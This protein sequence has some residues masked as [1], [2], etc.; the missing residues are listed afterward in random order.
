MRPVHLSIAGLVMAVAALSGCPTQP[1]ETDAGAVV[2]L[3]L[4]TAGGPVEVFKGIP[5]AAPPVGEMRWQPPGPA[6]SWEGIRPGFFATPPCMQGSGLLAASSIVPPSPDPCEDCLY[7][8]V[9]RP[10]NASEEPLPVMVWYHGGSFQSGT[11]DFPAY[12]GSALANQ[13]VIVVT[14][15]SRLGAFGYMAHP[16]F[17]AESPDGISGNYGVL[18]KIAALEWV[19]R[20]AAAFGGDPGN[21]TVF[22]ISSGA[23]GVGCLLVSP[24]AEGLF[25]RAI[26]QGGSTWPL[27]P[28]R[29]DVPGEDVPGE[30]FP[31]EL[32]SAEEIGLVTAESL[33]ISGTGPAAAAALRALPPADILEAENGSD[34]FAFRLGDNPT[35]DG[36]VIPEQPILMLQAGDFNR[37]PLLIGSNRDEASGYLVIYDEFLRWRAPQYTAFIHEFFGQDAE[38]ILALYPPRGQFFVWAELNRLVTDIAF[39]APARMFAHATAEAG[40]PAYRYYFTQRPGNI[41]GDVFGAHHAAEVPFVFNTLIARSHFTPED[42]ALARTMQ[43]YWTRFAATGDPNGPGDPEWPLDSPDADTLLELGPQIGAR[44]H[45][46]QEEADI[47]AQFLQGLYEAA[48]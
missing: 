33:A 1:V 37:I 18:D 17:S 40:L 26:M 3:R 7:L 45:Y 15:N 34:I 32:P 19:Q 46:R 29:A 27:P 43:R 22:G 21:V 12:D 42:R 39:F 14:V 35:V 30:V 44:S 11:G 13:G 23:M 36:V 2:G 25:H 9:W 20:N 41:A 28:L 10:A 4:Q 8:T 24:L 38:A 31:G 16:A 5:Y 48:R 47:L 6:P